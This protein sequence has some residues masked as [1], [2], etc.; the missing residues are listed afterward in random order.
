MAAAALAGLRSGM[1]SSFSVSCGWGKSAAT[2]NR[3]GR[4]RAPHRIRF[5]VLPLILFATRLFRRFD[6]LHCVDDDV[7]ARSLVCDLDVPAATLLEAERANGF[8]E[9]V[10]RRVL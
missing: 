10:H 9:V 3:H 4:R 1:D 2:A 7:A 5:I 8:E 6:P